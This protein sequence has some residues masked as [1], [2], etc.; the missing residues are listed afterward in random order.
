MCKNIRVYLRQLSTNV[1]Q[2][3]HTLL[4][5]LHNFPCTLLY[6]VITNTI[7]LFDLLCFP[8][9]PCVGI[10]VEI[11]VIKHLLYISEV[12]EWF[13]KYFSRYSRKRLIS[14]LCTDFWPYTVHHV[15][16][17]SFLDGNGYSHKFRNT[18]IS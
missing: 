17:M 3:Q 4:V 14:I 8:N 16:Y 2:K 5:L 1:E 6:N 7:Y 18:Y 10:F 15:R 12:S 9:Y 13:V 11:Y